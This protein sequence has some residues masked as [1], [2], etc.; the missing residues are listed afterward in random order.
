[1]LFPEIQHLYVTEVLCAFKTTNWMHF[2]IQNIFIKRTQS[3]RFNEIRWYWPLE[4]NLVWVKV[5]NTWLLVHFGSITLIA[6]LMCQRFAQVSLL[7]HK[8]KCHHSEKGTYL[9]CIIMKML[10][11]LW[12]PWRGLE[13]STVHTLRT[14][15]MQGAW[16]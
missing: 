3:S 5:K 13:A 11:I 8:C 12:T 10:L 7:C 4:K 6:V 15:V 1:M 2:V 9:L 16:I 14:A